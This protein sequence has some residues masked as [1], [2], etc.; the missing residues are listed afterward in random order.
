MG[1]LAKVAAAC[2]PIMAGGLSALAVIELTVDL[3]LATPGMMAGVGSPREIGVRKEPQHWV[4]GVPGA[5]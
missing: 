4:V 5:G 2:M 1:V 3:L